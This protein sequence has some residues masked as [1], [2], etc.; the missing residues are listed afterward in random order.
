MIKILVFATLV[1]VA[2][3][4]LLIYL[5]TPPEDR[6]LVGS[7]WDALASAVN[8]WM[9]YSDDGSLAYILLTAL[10]AGTGLLFTSILIGII[11]TAVEE[12]VNGLKNG[13]SVVL[14]RNHIV[15]LGFAAGEYTLLRQLISAAQGENQCIVVA[16]DYPKSEIEQYIMDNVTV[17]KNIRL[18]CRNVPA[19][20][21]AAMAVCSIPQCKTV[22]VNYPD[23]ADI[24]KATLAAYR[25]LNTHNVNNVRIIS[26]VSDDGFLLPH[27]IAVGM[28]IVCISTHDVLARVI[29]HSCTE[30][31][32]AGAYADLF[33]MEGGR[34]RLLKLMQ[35]IGKTFEE[36]VY[37]MDGAVPLGIES[38]GNILLNPPPQT[39]VGAGDRLICWA[40]MDK[41]VLLSEPVAGSVSPVVEKE[42]SSGPDHT[43]LFGSNPAMETLL[44][45]L[46]ERPNRVTAVG[47]P[48]EGR[49]A[50][51]R[52]A[53]QRSDVSVS[54]F[55][56]LLSDDVALQRLLSDAQHVAI[57]SDVNDPD[58]D[59]HGIMHYIR[60]NDF[61][62]RAQL[63]FSVTL[64][65]RSEQ[66][67]QLL[68]P[69]DP[70]DFIV[71]P[72]I[73][74]MFLAQLAD[75]PTI[76]PVFKELLSNTGSEIHLKPASLLGGTGVCTCAEARARLL[77]Q[78]MILLG[79]KTPAQSVLNPALSDAL[80]PESI[81][82]LIV[83]S[84][85]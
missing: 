50:L 9:P 52:F 21:M 20:D 16:G 30:T 19:G 32:I 25:I 31:G 80:H 13:N 39:V 53:A 17:P 68:E 6:D 74:A 4:T 48:P 57:L 27:N 65:L 47:F 83:I 8:A 37:T 64:E 23:D 29:A 58:S 11:A 44:R 45:E 66:H 43:I 55:D 12:K 73:V 26:S 28:Q 36:I 81:T 38:Q 3:I 60:I 82:N 5:L 67:L 71:A 18:I 59:M 14:E 40:E 1:I 61:K 75:C 70:T 7:F 62:K 46:P 85:T 15:V 54:F 79:Y 69:S 84:E 41:P 77:S 34:I 76:A 56:D 35:T 42:C 24:V 33:D 10:A 49:E 2:L 72:H 22:V 63:S 51:L 78:R